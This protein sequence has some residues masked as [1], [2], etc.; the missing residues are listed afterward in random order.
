MK[1]VKLREIALKKTLY[2]ESAL[3]NNIKHINY[4]TRGAKYRGVISRIQ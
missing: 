3:V 4:I 1:N 2:C